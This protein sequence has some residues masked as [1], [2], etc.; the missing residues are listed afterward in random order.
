[1]EKKTI[2]AGIAGA[3]IV[4]IIGFLAFNSILGNNEIFVPEKPSFNI[5]EVSYKVA[6]GKPEAALFEGATADAGEKTSSELTIYNQNL[7]L[8]K[9]VRNIMLEKGV[10]L[11]EF[12]DIAALIDA[13]SVFFRDL[14]NSGTFVVEQNYEYDLVSRQKILEKYLDK[15]ITVAIDEGNESREYTGKLLSFTDGVVLET[16]EGIVTLNPSRI[17]FPELPGGLLTKP[18]LVWKIYSPEAGKRNTET[19]YL[20]GGLSWRADYIAIANTDDSAI[21]F[22]GWTT[23]SNN[24]GTAY[25]DT[26]LKLVAGDVHRVQESPKYREVYDYAVASGAAVPEQFGEEALFEYHLYTLERKTSINN[27]ETKQISLLSSSGVP[28]KKEFVY[29]G[30]YNGN[31]VETKLNFKNSE[32][33]GLGMPLPKGIVRVYKKDLDGQLQFIGEDQIDHTKTEDN[34]ELLL[35]NA[36][37]VTGERTQTDYQNISKGVDRYSYNIKLENQKDTA[38]TVK[39]KEHLYGDWEILKNSQPFEKKNANDIEFTVNVPAKGT[40]EVTYTAQIAQIKRPYYG[41]Y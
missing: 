2:L 35:G 7:A 4:L 19:V 20:T 1:M 18:T 9:D 14:D 12:K 25:P 16:S 30:A 29:D 13:T 11:V 38:V 5:N 37:D 31:K 23:V 22:T 27:N 8:V 34:I 3:A 32:S 26:R 6:V 24:S 15:E 36:F 41:P 33:Q 17:N 39:V 21:D 40:A 28:V 10:N